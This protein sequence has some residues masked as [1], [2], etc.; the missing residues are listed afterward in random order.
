MK[1]EPF[2][3]M[4]EKKRDNRNHSKTK[5]KNKNDMTISTRVMC[6]STYRMSVSANKLISLNHLN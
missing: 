2:N 4:S 5:L 6:S 1:I 3:E